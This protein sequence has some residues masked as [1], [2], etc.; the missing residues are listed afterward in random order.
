MRRML[1]GILV[2]AA[3]FSAGCDNEVENGTLP[4]APA[5]TVSEIFTGNLNVNGGAT[6]TFAV[7]ATGTVTATLTEVTPDATLTTGFSLGSWNG[8]SC[9]AVIAK[10][11]ALQGNA[12]IGS[13]AGVG[14]LCVRVY[15]VGKFTDTIGYTLTVVHP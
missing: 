1:S 11:D 5:P 6:H 9:Q 2:I 13:A 14:L 10:D 8:Q 12:L 15:D 4:T 7:T 3:M